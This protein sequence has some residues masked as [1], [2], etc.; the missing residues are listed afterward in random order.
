MKVIIIAFIAFLGISQTQAQVTF[1]PGV[2]GGV[3]FAHFTKGDYYY[4]SYYDSTTGQYLSSRVKDES[5]SK[6]DF[7]IGFYGALKLTKHYTLQPEIDYSRQGSNFKIADKENIK[8]D[9]TYLSIAVV[10]KFAFTDKFNVHLGP[11]IDFIIERNENVKSDFDLAFQL[12][13][14]YHIT[15]NLGLE[16]RVKKGIV[17]VINYNDSHTNVVF[18]LG[19]SYTFD[20]K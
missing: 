17:P 15:P 11:T 4:N 7:Y 13:A 2:R 14:E 16:A 19:A 9:I 1:R 8:Y 6:T 10:N 5:S 3:N 12:G 18:S 20:L